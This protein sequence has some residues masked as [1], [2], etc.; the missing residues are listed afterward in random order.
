VSLCSS[1]SLL[2]PLTNCYLFKVAFRLNVYLPIS[3]H[4]WYHTQCN[5]S[6]SNTW[7]QHLGPGL[8]MN[9]N[10]VSRVHPITQLIIHIYITNWHK[11]K[12]WYCNLSPPLFMNICWYMYC[13]HLFPSWI[14]S[15]AIQT[16]LWTS[17][18]N[19][20]WNILHHKLHSIICMHDKFQVHNW[21]LQYL[22]NFKIIFW[23]DI[24]FSWNIFK[25]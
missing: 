24:L 23:V 11:Y 3:L 9:S 5:I 20:K 15:M 2:L 22:L 18:E 7:D 4:G 6:P 19:M 8:G 21:N 16:C 1:Y 25:E 17:C 14:K 12:I 13:P 10:M